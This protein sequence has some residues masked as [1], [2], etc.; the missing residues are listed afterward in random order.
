MLAL[1]IFCKPEDGQLT[2]MSFKYF[3]YY[4]DLWIVCRIYIFLV[5]NAYLMKVF[6]IFNPQRIFSVAS[7]V[8]G[9]KK[10]FSSMTQFW[11]DTHNIWSCWCYISIKTR[12]PYVPKPDWTVKIIATSK[13]H[14]FHHK[15]SLKIFSPYCSHSSLF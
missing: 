2:E 14:F 9:K 10:A 4:A 1:C 13:T 5:Y 6:S 15:K 8:L 11:F 7:K 12:N 3:C